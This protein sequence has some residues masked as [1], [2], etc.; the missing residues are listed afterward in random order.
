VLEV[1]SASMAKANFG[2]GSTS[3]HL[4]M[5]WLVS[6]Q[7]MVKP[8]PGAGPDLCLVLQMDE[9][10]IFVHMLLNREVMFLLCL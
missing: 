1:H 2:K 5:V 6:S 3:W 9:K 8:R 7:I 10:E 4:H